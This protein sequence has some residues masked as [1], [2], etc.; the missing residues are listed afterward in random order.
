MKNIT[1]KNVSRVVAGYILIFIIVG[2]NTE[3]MA[4]YGSGY[5]GYG[6][7]GRFYH[8]HFRGGFYI[9]DTWFASPSIEVAGIPYYYYSGVYYTPTNGGALVAVPSPVAE[10]TVVPA[11][12]TPSGTVSTTTTKAP[13]KVETNTD[14]KSNDTIT[15]NVPN[16]GKG[17][18]PVKLIK[19]EKGYIGPQ[20]E[21]YPD[22][23]TVTELKTL[24]GK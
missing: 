23:P 24:Y 2:A 19:T 22:H 12:N 1:F 21:L 11:P 6:G 15:I 17:F 3:A 7:Y 14:R 9:G 10:Q 5:H 4:W 18:T 8:P 20:G 16:T 13:A